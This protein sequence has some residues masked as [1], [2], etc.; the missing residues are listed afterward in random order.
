MP[1]LVLGIILLLI[2]FLQDYGYKKLWDRGLSYRAY[3]SASE[4]FEGDRLF[5]REE[6]IN[7]KFLPLPWVFVKLQLS[8]H[9]NFIDAKGEPVSKDTPISLFAI[10]S[11]TAIK[12]R[13]PFVCG[14]RGVYTLRDGNLLVSNLLHTKEYS[15][16]VKLH[17]ELLV[18]PKLLEH[19][20]E[21]DL[22][23]KQLDG[24][25]LSNRIINPDPFE[26]RGLRE[27]QPTDPLRTVNF[28]ATAVAQ[29][30]MVNIYAPTATKRLVLALN[31]EDKDTGRA[32]QEQSIRLC[33]TLAERFVSEDAKVGFYTNG[34]RLMG[35]SF[36]M[37]SVVKNTFIPAS[38]SLYDIFVCLAHISLGFQC[39]AM[40]DYI[41][42]VMDRE[43]VY[44]FISSYIGDDLLEAFQG[45]LDRGI[46]AFLI[47][48]VDGEIGFVG[49]DRMVVWRV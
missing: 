5:L 40:A 46:E 13:K 34:R 11:N 23:Y 43:Q 12:R 28:K 49:T 9:I 22:L 42:Q 36:G 8:T 1:L 37:P 30:L 15:K 33:A 29:Q 26:F 41:A 44:V 16:D 35:H 3:F 20:E 17:G 4:A 31:L 47:V 25:V 45:L 14:K 19:C 7:K 10:M 32:L 39:D 18:F 27:Y 38:N 6:L 21:L 24:L 48:P 2:I